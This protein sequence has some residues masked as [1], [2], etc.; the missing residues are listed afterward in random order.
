VYY[1]LLFNSKK[2]KMTSINQKI[3]SAIDINEVINCFDN[4]KN[5]EIIDITLDLYNQKNVQ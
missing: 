3:T 1:L 2:K 4:L 5:E